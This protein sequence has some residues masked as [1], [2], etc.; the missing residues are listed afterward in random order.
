MSTLVITKNRK[1]KFG[2]SKTEEV[3][4]KTNG[5]CGYCGVKLRQNVTRDPHD[6]SKEP[7]DLFTLDHI[8]PIS[9]G[10]TKDIKNLLGSCRFCNNLKGNSDNLD[11][12]RMKLTIASGKM[13]KFNDRQFE[14]LLTHGIN[15]GKL[16]RYQ[17][18]FEKLEIK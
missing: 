13:T 1:N 4:N 6:H 9:K 14:W 15:L 8:K 11:Y 5:R 17:F 3:W 7:D 10:G 18:Y 16:I 2:G 12:L